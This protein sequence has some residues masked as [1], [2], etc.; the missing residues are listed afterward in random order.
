MRAVI[1]S[2]GVDLKDHGAWTDSFLSSEADM[3]PVLEQ[4]SEGSG[5][6]NVEPLIDE[7]RLGR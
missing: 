6:C 2:A 3:R 7:I 5:C 1:I 4:G